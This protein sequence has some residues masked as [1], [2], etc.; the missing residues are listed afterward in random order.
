MLPDRRRALDDD[1]NLRR[2]RG[3][4]LDPG[5]QDRINFMMTGGPFARLVGNADTVRRLVPPWLPAKVIPFSPSG[6]FRRQKAK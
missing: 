1:H 2:W 3:M 6:R 5:H 4:P